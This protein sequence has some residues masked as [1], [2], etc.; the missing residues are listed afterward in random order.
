M[1]KIIIGLL[2]SMLILSAVATGCAKKETPE[3]SAGQ[4]VNLPAPKV[5]KFGVQPSLQPPH[6]ANMKGFFTEIETKYNTKFELISFASGG[7]ENNALAAN[8]ISWAQYGMAPAIVGMEKAGGMLV[9]IDILEQTAIIS[10]K[11]INTVADLKGKT[12]AFPGKGS[13]QYPLMLKAL[14][15]AGLKEDDVVLLKMDASNMSTALEKGEIS[16]YIAWDPHTTKAISSGAGKILVKAEEVMPLKEG[17]Y[18]GEGVVVRKD[19]ADEY[20]DLTED[21]VKAIMKANDYIV[22]NLSETPALWSKA[23]GLDESIIKLSLDNNMSVFVKDISPDLEALNPYVKLLNE[24]GITQISDVDKFLD[25]HVIL[26]Y[27]KK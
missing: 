3:N 22:D 2:L 8:E 15:G 21:I 1:K 23:I 14:E 18:L 7:P 16:A 27:T 26:D 20:P 5:V 19:F 11:S 6:I 10:D 24:Y 4:T 13:Q 17:H 12:V 25:E 9:A